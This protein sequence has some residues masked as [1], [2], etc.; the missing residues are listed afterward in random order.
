MN[1]ALPDDSCEQSV[2]DGRRPLT[3]SRPATDHARAPGSAGTSPVVSVRRAK[4]GATFIFRTDLPDGMDPD[5]ARRRCE[6]AI[7][8]LAE[9]VGR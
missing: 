3:G 1:R 5:E 4:N 9:G 8:A 2:P 7:R 6:E